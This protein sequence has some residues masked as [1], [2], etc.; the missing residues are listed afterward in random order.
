MTRRGHLDSINWQSALAADVRSNRAERGVGVLTDRLDRGQ[1]DNNDECQHNGV[2]NS[3][4]AIFRCQETLNFA[5]ETLHGKTSKTA[6]DGRGRHATCKLKMM[7]SQFA[8]LRIPLRFHS[9]WQ[10]IPSLLV[11]VT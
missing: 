11:H 4:W 3:C 1:T 6:G 5:D 2:L 9:E 7:G 10:T 8:P